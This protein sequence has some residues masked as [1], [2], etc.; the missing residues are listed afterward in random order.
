MNSV[1]ALRVLLQKL[2]KQLG[3]LQENE[4]VVAGNNHNHKKIRSTLVEQQS[5]VSA[6]FQLQTKDREEGKGTLEELPD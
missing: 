3:S 1:T 6:C 2:N 4:I 5:G